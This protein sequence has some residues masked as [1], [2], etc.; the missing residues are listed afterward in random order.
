M[1]QVEFR[2]QLSKQMMFNKITESG[3]IRFSPM[4]SKKHSSL[5]LE[6]EHELVV[7]PTGTASYDRAKKTWRVSSQKYLKQKCAT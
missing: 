1:H 5:S 2:K 7:K 6:E 4:R 3:G